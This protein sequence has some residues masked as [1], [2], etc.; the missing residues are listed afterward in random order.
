MQ[1]EERT[2]GAKDEFE[3]PPLGASSSLETAGDGTPDAF[4]RTI[5]SR[6]RRGILE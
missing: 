5:G 4:A 3:Q 6:H 2:P 1:V